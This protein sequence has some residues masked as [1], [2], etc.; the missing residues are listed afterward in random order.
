MIS[1]LASFF[2]Y[3]I[4]SSLSVC[5]LWMMNDKRNLIQESQPI[6]EGVT[7][8]SES[9]PPGK[10]DF[11]RLEF[12]SLKIFNSLRNVSQFVSCVQEMLTENVPLCAADRCSSC[13]RIGRRPRAGVRH[14]IRPFMTFYVSGF[15]NDVKELIDW[16]RNSTCIAS[17]LR[18]CIPSSMPLF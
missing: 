10:T 17:S 11:K 1:E 16:S 2:I 18:F 14:T 15:H 6:S 8:R 13:W 3:V 12:S 5:F 9:N 7:D 4:K